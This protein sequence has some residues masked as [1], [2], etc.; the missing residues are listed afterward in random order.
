MLRTCG[1]TAVLGG[2]L[3]LGSMAGCESL[4]GDEPEQ[5]AVIGGLS[6]AAAGAL[7]DDDKPV[8]G[9][10]IGGAAGAGGGYLVGRE[11]DRQRDD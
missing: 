7:I 4:P 1:L 10:L 2:C 3:L 8:R 6:G 9:G 11:V 5:G